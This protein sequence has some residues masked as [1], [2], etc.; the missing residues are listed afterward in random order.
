MQQAELEKQAPH[1]VPILLT[2]NYK[3]KMNNNNHHRSINASIISNSAIVLSDN[4]ILST[5]IQQIPD[6]QSELKAL[7]TQLQ[8]LIND[9]GLKQTDKQDALQEAQNIAVAARFAGEENNGVIRKGLR[10]IKGLATECEDAAETAVKVGAVV[11]EI[12]QLFGL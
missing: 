11:T 1:A 4:G 5:R 9:S 6:D 10:Y 2:I 8:N 7:L 12:G 3:T